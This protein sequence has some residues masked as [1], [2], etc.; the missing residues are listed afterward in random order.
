MISICTVIC[1]CGSLK[2]VFVEHVCEY[3][4]FY[5]VH[6]GSSDPGFVHG[7]ATRP[8]KVSSVLWHWCV[9]LLL[10]YCCFWFLQHGN[11]SPSYAYCCSSY[12]WDSHPSVTTNNA[13]IKIPSWTYSPKTSFFAV[14][15]SSRNS[16]G[17]TTSECIKWEWGGKICYFWHLIH[18][19]NPWMMLNS[20]YSVCC[21]IIVFLEPTAQILNEDRPL[22]SVA[23]YS[24]YSSF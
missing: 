10:Q 3:A 12:R 13:W 23:K 24:S 20:Y 17:F 8:G 1:V 11:I 18:C 21:I 22:P 15:S 4:L 2:S 6:S 7:T 9:P 14:F 5:R 19:T 16:K